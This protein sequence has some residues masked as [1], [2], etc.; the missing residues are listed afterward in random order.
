MAMVLSTTVTQAPNAKARL[1]GWG[2]RKLGYWSVKAPTMPRARV[3]PAMVSMLTK[4]NLRQPVSAGRWG[5]SVARATNS[6]TAASRVLAQP[7]RMA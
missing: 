1:T 2:V 6:V 3:R 5:C 4:I 7:T